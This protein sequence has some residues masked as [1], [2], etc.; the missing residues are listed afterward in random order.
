MEQKRTVLAGWFFKL[1]FLKISGQAMELYAT[2]GENA[3]AARVFLVN[4]DST[5]TAPKQWGTDGRK[6]FVSELQLE[7]AFHLVVLCTGLSIHRY[8]QQT[9]QE[10]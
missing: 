3:R 7:Y 9:T 8:R 6:K 2:S 10:H 4:L 1:I 5:S